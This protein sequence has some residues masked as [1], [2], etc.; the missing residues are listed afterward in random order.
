MDSNN[1]LRVIR[2]ERRDRAE[3]DFARGEE[4]N[5]R[6]IEVTLRAEP[7]EACV[8]DVFVNMRERPSDENQVADAHRLAR[9]AIAKLHADLQQCP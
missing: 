5:V 6:R 8:V 9:E 3:V 4:T 2:L 1:V 7:I